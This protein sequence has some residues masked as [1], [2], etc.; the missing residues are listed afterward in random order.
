MET[1]QEEIEINGIRKTVLGVRVFPELKERLSKT[2]L[3]L[4]I[5]LSELTAP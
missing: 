2:A 4:G 1:I 5:T 3:E